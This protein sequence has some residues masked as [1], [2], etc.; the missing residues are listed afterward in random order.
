MLADIDLR[1]VGSS[2]LTADIAVPKDLSADQTGAGI[3]VT[4]VPARNTIFLSLA[5][6]WAEVLQASDI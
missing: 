2:T 1:V 6:A 5:L 3:P 4:Y